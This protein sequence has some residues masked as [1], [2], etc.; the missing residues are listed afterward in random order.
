MKKLKKEKEK[1]KKK[2]INMILVEI[3]QKRLAD[4]PSNA[5]PIL[6]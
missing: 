2:L 6:S 1:R 4:A 3:W 5:I